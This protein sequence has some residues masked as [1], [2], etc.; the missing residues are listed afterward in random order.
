MENFSNTSR[1][2]SSA[3]ESC[4]ENYDWVHNENFPLKYKF[5]YLEYPLNSWKDILYDQKNIQINDE[6]L[7]YQDVVNKI[8]GK[9]IFKN[10]NF[11][12][13]KHGVI[14][15]NFESIY[16]TNLNKKISP[17]FYVHKIKIDEFY[18]ILNEREYMMILKNNKIPKNTKFISILGEIKSSY[19]FSHLPYDRQ[20]NKYKEF[21]N[22]VNSKETNEFVILMYVY[23]QSFNFFQK[24]SVE[25]PKYFYPI[26]Y[27]YIP[28]IY[29]ENCYH[30]NY[31]ELIEQLK[32]NKKKIDIKQTKFKRKRRE[33]EQYLEEIEKKYKLVI[34]ENKKLKSENNSLVEE[35][36]KL[37]SE[38]NSLV[39]EIKKLKNDR[40]YLYFF[41][42]LILIISYFL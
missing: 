4:D 19:S 33:L 25:K 21:I 8:L 15:F 34:E 9:D 17:D 6:G 29:R 37:K 13:E 12:E 11:C 3:Q 18:Q 40:W 30:N 22:L 28:K 14:N 26:I 24:D 16:K 42:F 10:C 2:S 5:Y 31:N 41:L 35:I 1:S 36:K 39:E 23:D 38:N 20:R 7:Y 27:G 32:S